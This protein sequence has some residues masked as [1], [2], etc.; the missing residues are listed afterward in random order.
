MT[1][2]LKGAD[3]VPRARRRHRM[4]WFPREHGAWA[5]LLLPILAGAIAGG[6][7]WFQIP[8]LVCAVAGY[9]AFNA[10]SWWVKMPPTRRAAAL[11]PMVVY[12]SIAAGAGVILVGLTGVAVLVWFAI[13]A[14]GLGI[15]WLL[16]RVGA[17][18]S[19]ASGLATALAA[20]ILL[21]IAAHPDATSMATSQILWAAVF[22]YGYLAGTVFA[23]KSAIRERGSVLAL[24]ASVSWHLAWTVVAA[25][26][27]IAGESAGWLALWIGLTVRAVLLPLSAR[28]SPIRPGLLGVV[29]IVAACCVL[30]VIAVE[31]LGG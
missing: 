14:A 27:V 1:S 8:L 10:A 25:I 19:L 4:L 3:R 17:G 12:G 24:S 5:W 9:C 28:R 23:V 21:L 26:A 16:T 29:E 20:T 6:W 11:T 13:Q 22:V 2:L 15:A 30:A 31:H 18:R 7:A